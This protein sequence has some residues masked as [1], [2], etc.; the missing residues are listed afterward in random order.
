MEWIVLD[1]FPTRARSAVSRGR[2]LLGHVEDT[3]DD[4]H[5]ELEEYAEAGDSMIVMVRMVGRGK[6]SGVAVDTPSFPM[7]WTARDGRSCGWRCSTAARA[8]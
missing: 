4:F 8:R 1:D 6:D 7:V 5:A 2:A 3:F